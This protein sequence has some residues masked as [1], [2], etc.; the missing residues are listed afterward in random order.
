MLRGNYRYWRLLILI[1]ILKGTGTST[2]Y[3]MSLLDRLNE[4]SNNN[5]VI[6]LLKCC[7]SSAAAMNI[8]GNNIDETIGL[9]TGGYE[10]LQDNRVAKGFQQSCGLGE[11]MEALELFNINEI[12]GSLGR[13]NAIKKHS[14]RSNKV[15][16]AVGYQ[17]IAGKACR[18]RSSNYPKLGWS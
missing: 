7:K 12:S 15:K 18:C 14:W 13:A 1:A 9:L 4:V 5:A 2:D 10:V 3:A 17:C 16:S 6:Y 11:D 8:L